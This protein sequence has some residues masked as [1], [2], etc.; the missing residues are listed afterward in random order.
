MKKKE[1]GLVGGLPSRGLLMISIL[2]TAF[3]GACVHLNIPAP[4]SG[5]DTALPTLPPSHVA[6]EASYPEPTLCSVLNN[7]VPHT[8]SE[9]PSGHDCIQ[10]GVYKNGPVTCGGSGNDVSTTLNILF[11]L[12]QRCGVF[13]IGQASCGFDSDPAKRAAISVSAPV[14][15]NGWH[16]EANPS[17]NLNIQDACKITFANIDVTGMLTSKAQS[18]INAVSGQVSSQVKAHTD[19][20]NLASNAWKTAGN[21][22]KLRDDVWLNLDPQD[23]GVTPPSVAG[24]EISMS[25]ALIANP[26]VYFSSTAPKPVPEKPFP[27]APS[28]IAPS[29]QFNVIVDGV[30]SWA[31]I[32]SQ[33]NNAMIGK[34]YKWGPFSAKPTGARAY[35]GNGVA[36][37]A[38][39]FKGSITGTAYLQAKPVFNQAANTIQLKNVDFTLATKNVLATAG[40]WLLSVGIPA[41]LEAQ[42]YSLNA[43]LNK[44]GATLT[45]L[46]NQKLSDN[47]I[48]TGTVADNPPVQVLGLFVQ[49]YGVVVRAAASGTL[50]VT[51]Q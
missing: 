39:D 31:E 21:P 35:G 12:G 17:I 18:A 28:S 22:V 30:A 3:L 24:G 15:W 4:P 37:I 16:L 13:G 27:T 7:A 49:S 41:Y 32:S 1:T 9:N 5:T 48:L 34:T 51:G 11:R 40:G 36:I 19:I 47:L 20:T 29:N 6:V 14:T 46:L 2:T 23:I 25:A 33:L 38:V 26:I 8:I 42:T 10:W 44:L 45:P 43:P 50:T